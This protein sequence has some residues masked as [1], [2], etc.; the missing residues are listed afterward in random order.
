MMNIAKFLIIDFIMYILIYFHKLV[1]HFQQETIKV[2][3]AP[4]ESKGIPVV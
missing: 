2:I 3:K 4:S 1:Y